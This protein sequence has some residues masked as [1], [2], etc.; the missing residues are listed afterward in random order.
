MAQLFS[1]DQ[2]RRDRLVSPDQ[3]NGIGEIILAGE[4][5]PLAVMLH[6]VKIDNGSNTF[7]IKLEV[8]HGDAVRAYL[9]FKSS[10]DTFT[11]SEK[12]RALREVRTA[13]VATGQIGILNNKHWVHEEGNRSLDGALGIIP[14]GRVFMACSGETFEDRSRRIELDDLCDVRFGREQQWKYV[15]ASEPVRGR[16]TDKL[17]LNVIG[18][19]RAWKKGGTISDWKATIK[20]FPHIH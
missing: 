20:W 1:L 18:E 14:H 4:T 9:S 7:N 19:E 8:D 17:F 16:A 2:F 10:K 13:Q 12:V 6:S 15:V 3:R 11:I 5:K